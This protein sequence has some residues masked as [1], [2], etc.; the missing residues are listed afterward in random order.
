MVLHSLP[1]HWLR[2]KKNPHQGDTLVPGGYT[3]FWGVQFLKEFGV[4]ESVIKL[5]V[6]FTNNFFGV[7]LNTLRSVFF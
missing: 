1:T 2:L 6:G 3:W 5:G 7:V 4:V